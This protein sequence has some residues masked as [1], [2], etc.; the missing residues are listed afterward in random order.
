MSGMSATSHDGKTLAAVLEYMGRKAHTLRPR[1]EMRGQGWWPKAEEAKPCCQRTKYPSGRDVW[2]KLKHCCTGGHIAA[3]YECDEK[4]MR[5]VARRLTS[6]SNEVRRE[7]LSLV[8]ELKRSKETF[9]EETLS[10]LLA[11][12]HENCRLSWFSSRTEELALAAG[13]VRSGIDPED[14]WQ[15]ARALSASE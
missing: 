14:A 4:V 13:L 12:W 8:W 5:Q 2:V 7:H 10:Q 1:G 15:S 11:V 6:T 3:L 9:S